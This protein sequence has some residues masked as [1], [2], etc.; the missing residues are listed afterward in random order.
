M[1]RERLTFYY[2]WLIVFWDNLYSVHWED[3]AASSDGNKSSNT[4]TNM[5]KALLTHGKEM[6]LSLR[7]SEQVFHKVCDHPFGRIVE[8]TNWRLLCVTK[9]QK[10][11]KI[12]A[13]PEFDECRVGVVIRQDD[14]E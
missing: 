14:N 6:T 12:T 13:K 2:A 8:L 4:S 11:L 10:L 7:I 5:L 1:T 3:R 9:H